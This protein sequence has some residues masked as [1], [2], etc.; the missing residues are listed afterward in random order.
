MSR[1]MVNRRVEMAAQRRGQQSRSP[2][3]DGI[4]AE[5]CG[6]LPLSP[7]EATQALGIVRVIVDARIQR[8]RNEIVHSGYA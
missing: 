1:R 6:S 8:R 2:R 7:V 5:A 4:V 3:P